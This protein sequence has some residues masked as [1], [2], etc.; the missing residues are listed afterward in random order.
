MK[1]SL[2]K[3]TGKLCLVSFNTIGKGFGAA[4]SSRVLNA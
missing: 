4:K 1:G 2:F 3:L